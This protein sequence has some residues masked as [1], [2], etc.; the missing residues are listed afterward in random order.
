MIQ[1]IKIEH[2]FDSEGWNIKYGVHDV[3]QLGSL[4]LS[5]QHTR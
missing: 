3:R 4:D 5:D 2:C 1:T